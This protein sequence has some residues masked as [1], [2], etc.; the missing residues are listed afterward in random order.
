LSIGVPISLYHV[1]TDAVMLRIFGVLICLSLSTSLVAQTPTY[2]LTLEQKGALNFAGVCVGH[3]QEGNGILQR[4]GKTTNFNSVIAAAEKSIARILQDNP[5]SE[6]RNEFT[7][8]LDTTRRFL[9][10][11]PDSAKSPIVMGFLQNCG[12][13]YGL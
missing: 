10:G 2:S 9:A 13:K 5:S 7:G 11:Q 8:F 4:R 1:F 3:A 12:A 6:A